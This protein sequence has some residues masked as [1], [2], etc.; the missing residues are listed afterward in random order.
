MI[1]RQSENVLDGVDAFL[2]MLDHYDQRDAKLKRIRELEGKGDK[3]VHDIIEELNKTFITPIDRE[4]ITGLVSSLDDILD[5]VEAVA[6]SMVL[7]K[8][9]S[10][11]SHMLD[12]A[13]T[14]Q[15]GAREVNKAISLLR[16]FKEAKHIREHLTNINTMENEADTLLHNAM[17]ELFDDG[18]DAVYIIKMKELYDNLETATDKCEDAAD[19]IGD[20]LVK[21]T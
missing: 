19:V 10:P 8:I 14:L 3:M 2:D 11:D 1:E 4:D 12:L 6:V 15:K 16:D 18:K 9:P 21:Y 7:Y 17:A 5:Y 20:I 13:R